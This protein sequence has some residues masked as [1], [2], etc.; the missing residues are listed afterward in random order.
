MNAKEK[1][2]EYLNVNGFDDNQINDAIDLA[3]QETKKEII[4]KIDKRF[5][6]AVLNGG[7]WEEI[8]LSFKDWEELKKELESEVI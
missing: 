2:L 6:S 7:T 1:A 4:E 3:I 8:R 5:R